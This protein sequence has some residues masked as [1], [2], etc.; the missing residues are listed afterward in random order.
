MFDLMGAKAG[1]VDQ[2]SGL[3]CGMRVHG[4]ASRG[5]GQE[6]LSRMSP[7]HGARIVVAVS[8]CIAWPASWDQVTAQ[9]AVELECPPGTQMQHTEPPVAPET[10]CEG[11]T[12]LGRPIR[13]GPAV[14]Y[15]GNGGPHRV[16]HYDLGRQ[17]G[18]WQTFDARGVLKR[19][20]HRWY[21]ATGRAIEDPDGFCD[22]GQQRVRVGLVNGWLED[23]C[24]A[25]IDGRPIQ[26]GLEL[27][28]DQKVS[29]AWRQSLGS[30]CRPEEKVL[31]MENLLRIM[32]YGHG[33]RHGMESRWQR[34]GV[35]EHER[36]WA[37]G[38]LHG[39]AQHYD[40][41][42]RPLE[43][44]TW[45]NGRLHGPRTAYDAD[46]QVRW[47]ARYDQGRLAEAEGDLTVADQPCPS[48]TVPMSS[49]D[50]LSQVCERNRYGSS[51]EQHGPY[52]VWSSDGTLMERGMYE[53]GRKAEIWQQPEGHA[54]GGRL[55]AEGLLGYAGR[56][57]P[58]A[59]REPP[60]FWFRDE[61]RGG[62]VT[63]RVEY[64]D[65]RVQ[66]YGLPDGLYFMSV[67]VDANR[68][69]LS[70]YPG[71]LRGQTR[72]KVTADEVAEIRLRLRGLIHMVA[73]ED[74]GVEMPSWGAQC[75]EQPAF[76]GPLRF[77]WKRI[78]AATKYKYR[79]RRVACDP[80][81]TFGMV[82]NGTV[83][84]PEVTLD[85]PPNAEGEIYY[86]EIAAFDHRSMIATLM[87]H[88]EAGHGW[89][90]R[91]RVLGSPANQQDADRARSA[92][93]KTTESDP[94]NP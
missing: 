82:A 3:L 37:E 24:M 38:R 11:T 26:H 21:G 70:S 89:D 65:S 10:W 80:F 69:N 18:C 4:N 13:H 41:E 8:I 83:K 6:R 15:H 27:T 23:H 90:Y 25:V 56:P 7:L 52:A 51:P 47:T 93:Q 87:T 42:G 86:I 76:P 72:F 67:T 35:L 54:E 22:D 85:L 29:K 43:T 36:S 78:D 91:F 32:E 19:T 1:L 64:S 53:E 20:E 79:V 5:P 77:A 12:E 44:A 55:V 59:T 17:H 9:P 31:P 48:D 2:E 45:E 68:D 28:Y 16:G 74:N 33:K 84:E 71:D 62:V 60:K 49:P 39:I 40:S 81:R 92:P 58:H 88:G 46:G 94:P 30:G 63:P 34:P 61:E 14:S 73:P 66:I 57:L 75:G 50:R